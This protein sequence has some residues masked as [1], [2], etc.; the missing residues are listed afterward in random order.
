MLILFRSSGPPSGLSVLNTVKQ[1]R[2]LQLHQ[3]SGRSSFLIY[4][5]T[6]YKD[7]VGDKNAQMDGLVTVAFQ[8]I[9]C[10]VNQLGWR[11]KHTMNGCII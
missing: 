3:K 1:V 11:S 8:F 9:G 7:V 10:L 4:G 5:G 6:Y 2:K